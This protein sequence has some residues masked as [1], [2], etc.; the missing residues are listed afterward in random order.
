MNIIGKNICF[1]GGS[2]GA[3]KLFGELAT[4]AGH[5]VYHWSFQGHYSPC[6]KEQIYQLS[7][8]KL[9][10]AD[11]HLKLANDYL[12]RTWPTSSEYVNNLLRRN[13]YQ[14]KYASQVYATTPF[15]ENMK[16]LGGTS[17]AILMAMERR[18]QIYNFDPNDQQ[19]YEFNYVKWQKCNDV[20]T[21]SGWY[22][23]IGS[24]ELLDVAA[25]VIKELYSPLIS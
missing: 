17:W 10:E 5:K 21:P 3:D 15:D 2:K 11:K 1:S 13:Y 12:K 23:G 8:S 18:I 6:P 16:P 4:K 19:W 7:Y 9:L 20:P 25:N 14:I 22:A 24:S